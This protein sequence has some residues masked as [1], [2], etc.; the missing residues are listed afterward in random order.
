M[1]C[2]EQDF[3]LKTSYMLCVLLC[4]EAQA[5]VVSA[6]FI[7]KEDAGFTKGWVYPLIP[8]VGGM[9]FGQV[10]SLHAKIKENIQQQSNTPT[11]HFCYLSAS[12]QAS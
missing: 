4:P 7:S 11:L 10:V 12:T 2:L 5:Q 9:H 8:A 3:P 6:V 1:N